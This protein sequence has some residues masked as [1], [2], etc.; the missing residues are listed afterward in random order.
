M[1]KAN[2]TKDTV[3]PDK[4]KDANESDEALTKPDKAKAVTEP[5]ETEDGTKAD[6]VKA[7]TKP[8]KVKGAAKPFRASKTANFE[9]TPELKWSAVDTPPH[10]DDKAEVRPVEVVQEKELKR[11]PW[12]LLKD[13]KTPI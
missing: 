4:T 11:Q 1:A 5:H 3:K 12:D 8:N 2:K 7:T 10:K 13:A 6:K 9:Q